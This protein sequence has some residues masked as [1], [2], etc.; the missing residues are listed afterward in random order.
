MRLATACTGRAARSVLCVLMTLAW[1]GAIDPR[2]LRAQTGPATQRLTAD[3]L[4][5]TV[6]EM[7]EIASISTGQTC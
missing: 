4:Q 6:K 5:R 2:A 7:N 3:E 1:S